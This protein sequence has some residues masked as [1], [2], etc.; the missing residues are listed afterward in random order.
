MLASL[1]LAVCSFPGCLS[2]LQAP[3]AIE[4][5]SY[6]VPH[7]YADTW[8]EAFY[9]AG[10]A[11]AEDR[12][13]QLEQSRRLARGKLAEAFGKDFVASDRDV[14]KT[15]YT[16]PELQRQ[17][18]ALSP[19]AKSAFNEYA[20]G[21]N[22]YIQAATAKN[23]LPPGYAAAGLKPEP[24]SVLDSAAI[25]IRMFQLFGR[26]DAGELR[27]LALLLYLKSQ[28]IKDRAL[29]VFDDFLWQND[30]SSPTTVLPEDDLAPEARPKFPKALR[31]HTEKQLAELPELALFDIL[32]A[33]KLAREERDS[34][35]MAQR[36]GVLNKAGSYAVVVSKERSSTGWPLLLNGPQ[37]GFSNPSIVHEMSMAGPGL[38]VTGMDVPGTPGVVI[39]HNARLAWGLTS[40]VADTDD[41]FCFK[42]V[43][44]DGYLKDGEKKQLATVT[45]T[46]RVKGGTTET[47]VQK[48]TEEG[49]VVLEAKGHLFAV[50]SASWM[51]EL[52][53]LQ[54]VYALLDVQSSRD[55]DRA[56]SSATVNFNFFFAFS[57]GDIG[58]RYLGLLPDRPENT[59]PR[60]P[61]MGS[62]ANDW[63]GYLQPS[64]LPRVTNPK[65]GLI[66]NW[67]NKPATWFANGDTPAWGRL[68]RVEALTRALDKSRLAAADL[69][70]AI[71][72]IARVEPF[73]PSF[74]PIVKAGLRD[75]EYA[76]V[77]KDASAYLRAFDGRMV[78]G[79]PSATVFNEFFDALRSELFLPTTG[80]FLMPSV[81][82]LAAQPSVM[83]AALQGTTSVKYL[84][85]RTAEDVVRAAFGKAASALEARLGSDPGLWGFVPGG[86]PVPGEAPIPYGN[87]GT[88]IQLVELRTVPRGRSVLPPGVAESGPH[89]KDQV[90][91]SRAWT[92]KPMR[93]RPFAGK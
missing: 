61:L 57:N 75:Q 50:R 19:R 24:W 55:I 89:S 73:A 25:T 20:R 60:L 38:G 18:D 68:F 93:V 39:G 69:E 22:A 65:G 6:G 59:D 12:L 77:G 17:F 80:N 2:S 86:I 29:D 45:H 62:K 87:R 16:E 43:G 7:I 36:L 79:S 67:N 72:T 92:F 46:L 23:D 14:L 63:K 8:E 48:R 84:K 21:V 26:R 54:A 66:A 49:V 9:S 15:G 85:E 13:W 76:G 34:T 70:S 30:P 35:L 51:R 41:V 56:L 27:N 44:P 1:L 64:Q 42:A 10:Y 58:Y 82:R 71:W 52:E 37:M 91:L 11:V 5:D 33:L 78:D 53:S 40:G 32:P 88:Y 31:A 81:F 28:P 74:M 47:V 3:S 90:P 4:R 83:L